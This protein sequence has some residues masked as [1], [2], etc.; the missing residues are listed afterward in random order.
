LL[1]VAIAELHVLKLLSEIREFGSLKLKPRY[2]ASSQTFP[3]TLHPARDA[4]LLGVNPILEYATGKPLLSIT[5]HEFANG[6]LHHASVLV[7]IQVGYLG[8]SPYTHAPYTSPVA[9][10]TSLLANRILM[11]VNSTMKILPTT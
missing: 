11:K 3:A 7:L 8:S 9:A 1:D 10:V 4:H 5:V 2:A 6:L